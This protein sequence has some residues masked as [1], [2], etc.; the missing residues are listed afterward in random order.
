MADFAASF[1]CAVVELLIG[2][3]M[4]VPSA[5]LWETLAPA[6]AGTHPRSSEDEC[7]LEYLAGKSLPRDLVR[8]LLSLRL[9][10]SRVIFVR[11]PCCI[12]L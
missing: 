10:V 9:T 12:P 1:A 11:I 6:L 5:D 2:F 3:T 8:A 4:I 7:D